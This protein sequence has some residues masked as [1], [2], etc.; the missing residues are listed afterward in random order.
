MKAR[1]PGH[2]LITLRD[3]RVIAQYEAK[4]KELE[5]DLESANLKLRQLEMTIGAYVS[6]SAA[7]ADALRFAGLAVPP[8]VERLENFSRSQLLEFLDFPEL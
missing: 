3:D 2:L 5:K 6:E 7:L 1:F 8:S 4:I